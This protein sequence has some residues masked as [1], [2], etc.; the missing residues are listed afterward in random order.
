MGIDRSRTSIPSRAIEHR[1]YGTGTVREYK[2]TPEELEEVR[3]KYPASTQDKKFVKP[4]VQNTPDK[5][6]KRMGK[7][8]M[9]EAE[10]KAARI[11][12]KT[13]AKIAE[14]QDVAEATVYKQ[15]SKWA[16][17]EKP[18]KTQLLRE[19]EVLP[20][21]PSPSDKALHEVERLTAELNAKIRS[22]DLLRQQLL[23]TEEAVAKWKAQ[24]ENAT[25]QAKRE[26]DRLAERLSNAG[27]ERDVLQAELNRMITERDELVAEIDE[28]NREKSGWIENERILNHLVEQLRSDLQKR[29]I[30]PQLADKP[31]E[32]HLLDRSIAELTRAK[33]I[34][35]QLSASG[36]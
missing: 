31:S 25:V 27:M 22:N 18:E 24:A 8:T 30:D 34:L 33:W 19:K 12:G 20:P 28:L 9:T 10:F 26:N 6:E 2:L 7:F 14:E 29:Q 5:G 32:V 23:S 36:Q 11:S 15:M 21:V 3:Q 4:I 1:S 17:E 35:N 13:I 16:A